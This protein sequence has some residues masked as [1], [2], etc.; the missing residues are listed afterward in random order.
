MLE[1]RRIKSS[2]S[3]QK[4]VNLGNGKWYYNYDIQSET[5]TSRRGEDDI[6]ETIYN[7][8]Q[9]K[10]KSK[11]EYKKC[12][13]EI[14]RQY[15]TQSQEFDLINGANKALIERSSE[16]VPSKYVE[17]LDLLD[18]IKSKVKNDFNL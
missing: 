13:E 9:I 17:Y 4:F 15:I 11:P 5:V 16:G 7:Y 3:P 2:I 6:T 18:E 8:I 14:I 1:P 12:V 10:L